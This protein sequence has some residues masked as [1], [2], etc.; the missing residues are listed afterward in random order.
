MTHDF[1]ARFS[2]AADYLIARFLAHQKLE[3][4]ITLKLVQIENPNAIVEVPKSNL[5][6]TA[7]KASLVELIYGLHT[8]RC[9][10]DGHIELVEIIRSFEKLCSVDLENFHKV[11]TEVKARK[12]NRTKFLQSLQ[13]TLER[14]FD[15]GDAYRQL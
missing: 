5:R 7:S 13:E 8:T 6:W 4:Y 9:F 10:N 2:T 3:N 1:D 12:M 15:D 14:H 11:L